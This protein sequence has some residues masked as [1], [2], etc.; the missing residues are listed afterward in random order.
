MK[1]TNKIKVTRLLIPVL[2]LAMLVVSSCKP[3]ATHLTQNLENSGVPGLSFTP[4]PGESTQA[5]GQQTAS[6]QPPTSV[7]EPTSNSIEP[8][9]TQ[10]PSVTLP[11]VQTPSS[12]V[13]I[14]TPTVTSKSSTP[15]AATSTMAPTQSRTSTPTQTRTP[16]QTAT[17]TPSP[18]LQ[19]GWAGEWVFFVGEGDGPY[20]SADGYIT[21]DDLLAEGSFTL[22][23]VAFSFIA[24]L[25]EDQSNLN[26][27]Y[28][29]G[30]T[31]G[32]LNWVM[33]S[34][35]V[36]FRGT[37]DNVYAFCAAR[38]GMS[39]PAPCGDYVPY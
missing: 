2:L 25:S 9:T 20:K 19:T 33:D 35:Y 7:S 22:D 39:M 30:A 17:L 16:T 38:D 15:Q 36:Q 31:E 4:T 18:T 27:R 12:P 34:N 29:W 5:I 37:L 23:G 10:A 6:A 26:G 24:S 3:K 32:W 11:P 28:Q 8:L 21:L 13:V 14:L 1:E